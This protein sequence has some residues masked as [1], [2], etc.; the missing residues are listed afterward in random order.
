MRLAAAASA[1][2]FSFDWCDSVCQLNVMYT[3]WERAITKTMI[4]RFVVRTP[5]GRPANDC[6]SSVNNTAVVHVASMP[7]S[8]RAD[9]N[10]HPIVAPNSATAARLK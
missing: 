1:R 5:T 6:T 9:L 7:A 4:P 2:P 10:T 8:S 3:R